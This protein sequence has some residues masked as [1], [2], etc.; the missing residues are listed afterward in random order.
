M[1]FF[2]L[3]LVEH[4]QRM[5]DQTVSSFFFFFFFFFNRLCR[6]LALEIDVQELH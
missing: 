5:I 1:R 4:L 6:S 2:N 3:K